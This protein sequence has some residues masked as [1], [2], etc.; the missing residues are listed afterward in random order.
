MKQVDQCC[1]RCGHPQKV[2]PPALGHTCSFCGH[3]R[4]QPN[5]AACIVCACTD[6]QPCY[7]GCDWLAVNREFRVGVCSSCVKAEGPTEAIYL[8][9]ARAAAS[10]MLRA[11]LYRAQHPS[12]SLARQQEL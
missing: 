2:T 9:R 1:N 7:R 10:T 3:A 12:F 6:S 5:D 11:F 8:E 4:L